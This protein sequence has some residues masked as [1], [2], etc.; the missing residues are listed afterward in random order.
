LF[1]ANAS[2]YLCQIQMEVLSTNDLSLS[3]HLL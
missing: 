2:Q 1:A 3:Q